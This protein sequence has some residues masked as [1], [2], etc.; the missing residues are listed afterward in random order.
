MRFLLPSISVLSVYNTESDHADLCGSGSTTLH[1]T[2]LIDTIV[3]PA[4]EIILNFL[5]SGARRI[6]PYS[7]VCAESIGH[8]AQA[9]GIQVEIRFFKG[10]GASKRLLKETLM[11]FAKI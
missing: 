6:P 7:T 2:N 4:F 10:G 5:R 11:I 3:F 8:A 1:N 9:L